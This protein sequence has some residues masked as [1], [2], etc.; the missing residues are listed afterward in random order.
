LTRFNARD[1]TVVPFKIVGD[2]FRVKYKGCIKEG[3]TNNHYRINQHIPVIAM[4]AKD[5][6]HPFGRIK[7]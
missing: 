3:E 7:V 5:A 6:S 4:V 2:L 1:K